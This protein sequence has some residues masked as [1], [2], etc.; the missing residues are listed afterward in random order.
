[1]LYSYLFLL[2]RIT[3]VWTLFTTISYTKWSKVVKIDGDFFYRKSS[4]CISNLPHNMF[5][6]VISYWF[7]CR[8]LLELSI[9]FDRHTKLP[10]TC[11]NQTLE[12]MSNS[13]HDTK[14][15]NVTQWIWQMAYVWVRYLIIVLEGEYLQHLILTTN[16]EANPQWK[17]RPWSSLVII[18]CSFVRYQWNLLRISSGG[19][20]SRNGDDK[21]LP[22]PTI[23]IISQTNSRDFYLRNPSDPFT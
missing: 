4:I 17:L 8:Q 22:K 11:S 3:D 15:S 16:L 13:K 19:F 10:V 9:M 6:F 2:S 12:V 1:M 7:S 21:V 18:L 20:Y 14:L 23:W 5:Q